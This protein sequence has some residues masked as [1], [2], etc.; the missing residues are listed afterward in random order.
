MIAA[1]AQKYRFVR[2]KNKGNHIQKTLS[3]GKQPG[4]SNGGGAMLL[5]VVVVAFLLLV[6]A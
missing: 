6:L 3:N 2:G 1:L 4:G 5:V